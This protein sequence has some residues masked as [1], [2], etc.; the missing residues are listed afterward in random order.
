MR[1][2]DRTPNIKVTLVLAAVLAAGVAAPAGAADAELTV[3]DWAGYEDP[4]FHPDYVEQ[5]GDS[6][7]FT[8]FGDEDEAFQKLRAGFQ[9]DLAHPCSQ[10][11]TKWREAGLLQPLDTSRIEAWDDILPG[12]K[13]IRNLMTDSEGTAWFVPFDWGN[14]LVTYRTDKVEESEIQSL[15][16][17]ADPK[18]QGRVSLPDNVDDAYALAALATGFTDWTKMTDA[19]WDDA[20]AF[21]RDVHKNV[22]LYWL[23]NTELSQAMAGG[24]VDLAWAWNETATTLAADGVPVAMK[25]DTDEGLSTWVCGY[26]HLK[27]A[28]GNTDK[29]YDFLN[30][31]LTPEVTE[32]LVGEW[33]YGHA[34]AKGMAEIDPQVLEST[35]YGD[36][37]AFVDKTLFSSPLPAETKQKLI[38][39]FEK[40]KAGY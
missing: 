23:D 34:N 16:A 9:A 4:A 10:N 1:S 38:A 36:V 22:R 27:D 6:P 5:H 30:A 17:F 12:L 31:T 29:V 40:I 11:T 35:G 25:R 18:F 32:Y 24:E 19:D 39:E 13:N 15:Q 37:E 28:P 33:G 2:L 20:S 7:T 8:F 26:V 3:F 14:T 21:L